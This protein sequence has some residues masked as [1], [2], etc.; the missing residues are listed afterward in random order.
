LEFIGELGYQRVEPELQQRQP[1]QQQQDE[2]EPGPPGAG[3]SMRTT[4]SVSG[5]GES[6]LLHPSP[7]LLLEDLFEAYFSCRRN[8]RNT[9]N[10]TA[11]EVD[12]ESQL[13]Q[14]R[15][16][17]ISGTYRPRRSLAFIVHE[18]VQREIFAA[19]FRD[20]VVHH[21]VINKLNP[22]FEREFI[23]D[24]Y[25]CRMGRGT[26]FGIRR[27]DTFIRRASANYTRDCFVLRLDI[28]GFFMHIDQQLLADRLERFIADKYRAYDS[29]L[30]ARLC[31]TIV[32]SDPSKHCVIRGSRADWS[33]LPP[34]KSLFTSPSGCGLPIG[35]LSSQVFANF[36][37]NPFDHFVKHDLGMRDYGR[38]V[39]DLVL[40][41]ESREHLASLVPVIRDYLRRELRLELHPKKIALQ[42]H[43][44][45]VKYLGAV[46]MPNRIY[47]GNRTK[48]NFHDALMWHNR[49]IVP[50]RSP[51]DAQRVA[52]QA[53]ANSYLGLM[54]QFDTY[55]LRRSMLRRGGRKWWSY[56][57][58]TGD[59]GKVV[60]RRA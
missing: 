9:A 56:S 54:K 1:E 44:H 4:D 32:L 41:H 6:T 21:L 26:L 38:Y 52:F 58:V 14:L 48:A 10:A 7:S 43:A 13:V 57:H 59:Y 53:S 22:L 45:G 49:V 8:K 5:A 46:I 23:H 60:V 30:V 40:V 35:N 28:R 36:Y 31:R 29:S 2:H 47:V 11:F 27:V 25:A 19:H 20:R 12:F 3:F 51:S 33:G 37:L 24:S 16:E 34:D 50:G 42:H 18:P 55:R 39:D 15:D 17:I